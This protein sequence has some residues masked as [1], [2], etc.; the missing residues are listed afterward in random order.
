MK[1]MV[2]GFHQFGHWPQM[3]P[4]FPVNDGDV[5]DEDGD[6]N[7]DD[8]DNDDNDDDEDG[9]GVGICTNLGAGPRCPPG[10][11]SNSD[12]VNVL[13]SPPAT[14]SICCRGGNDKI[15]ICLHYLS[16]NHW[17]K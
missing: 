16:G 11:L 4:W 15:S 3:P 12:S 9:D 17:G 1:M 10:F 14:T 13:Y 2:L 6:D 7:H 5:D 8:D